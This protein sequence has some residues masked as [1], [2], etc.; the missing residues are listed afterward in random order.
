MLTTYL[1][2]KYVNKYSL[3]CKEAC[4]AFSVSSMPVKSSRTGG[5]MASAFLENMFQY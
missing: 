1:W 5:G 2:L 4:F 3:L